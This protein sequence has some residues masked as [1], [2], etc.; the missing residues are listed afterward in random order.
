MTRVI[1]S[2]AIAAALMTPLA[3][4][5]DTLRAHS[6]ARQSLRQVLDLPVHRRSHDDL[7]FVGDYS[8]AAVH[9]R[10]HGLIAVPANPGAWFSFH[11]DGG[12]SFSIG[13]NR[14]WADAEMHHGRITVGPIGGTRIGCAPD[15]AR[16]ESWMVHALRGADRVEA[17]A[18]GI[19]FRDIR[20]HTLLMVQVP[21]PWLDR[22][23]TRIRPTR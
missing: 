17:G 9:T 20:G 1:P 12:L 11:A 7:R 18:D 8:P 21:S 19:R 23:H 22:P 5:A 6:P 15:L 3:A 16:L 2:F 14:Y 13:C 10:R 4:A